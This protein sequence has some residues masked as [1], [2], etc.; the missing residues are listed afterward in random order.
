MVELLLTD[1]VPA[2]VSS[3]HERRGER[4]GVPVFGLGE[5]ETDGRITGT[6]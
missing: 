5:S 3:S 2:E 6:P 4:H 1:E